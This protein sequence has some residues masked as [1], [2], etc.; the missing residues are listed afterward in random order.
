MGVIREL[1]RFAHRMDEPA[2][3]HNLMQTVHVLRYPM[4][5]ILEKVP[6]E[7]L[8]ERAK[9]IG[10]S[11]QTM[12]VWMHER[13]RPG[14]EQATLISELTG[15]PVWQI[16]DLQEGEGDGDDAGEKGAKTRGRVAKD[17]D[18]FSARK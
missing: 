7:T 10:V 9:A 13:F 11:R 18:G 1:E 6:G 17:G 2:L 4:K 5:D 12:Y 14:L 16:R 15:I 3:R 8:T